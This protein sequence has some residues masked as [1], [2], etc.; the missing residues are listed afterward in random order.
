MKK[1]K[2]RSKTPEK[3]P[4]TKMELALRECD[5]K[6][7]QIQIRVTPELKAEWTAFL[8]K[9]DANGSK[10]IREAMEREIRLSK[11]A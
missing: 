4:T 6:K 9:S 1:T 10:L 7:T 11:I 2:S 5:G 3:I 8:E